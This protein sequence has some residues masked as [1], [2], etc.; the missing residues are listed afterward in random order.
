MG[1]LDS[2]KRLFVAGPPT[3]PRAEQNSGL[4]LVPPPQLTK[5]F[6]LPASERVGEFDS[7]VPGRK[8]QR[9][10]DREAQTPNPPEVHT[11]RASSSTLPCSVFNVQKTKSM[12][13][14]RSPVHK[15][16]C[17]AAD[18]SRPLLRVLAR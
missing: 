13:R 9:L 10:D 15:V 14:S 4:D 7:A 2:L 5:P 12:S 16:S 17:V 18:C 11:C 1:L 8:L 6:E 3:T